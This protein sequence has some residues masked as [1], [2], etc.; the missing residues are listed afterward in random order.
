MFTATEH[1]LTNQAGVYWQQLGVEFFSDAQH[2][3]SSYLLLITPANVPDKVLSFLH[4]VVVFF[5]MHN[6]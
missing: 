2:P 6:Y 4:P 3:I 5:Q 1:R